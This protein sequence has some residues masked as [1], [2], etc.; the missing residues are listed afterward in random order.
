MAP[1]GT[2]FR[3]VPA[4]FHHWIHVTE[5]ACDASLRVTLVQV[6]SWS[7]SFSRSVHLLYD[8]D[9]INRTI[10]INNLTFC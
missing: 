9:T 6:D 10:Q 4:H 7:R 5:S 8:I 2:P 3:P 1:A